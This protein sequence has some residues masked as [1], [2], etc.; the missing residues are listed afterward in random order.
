MLALARVAKNLDRLID[1]HEEG[2]HTTKVWSNLLKSAQITV[3]IKED[4]SEAVNEPANKTTAS[5]AN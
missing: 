4:Q 2:S 5:G 3:N 1:L